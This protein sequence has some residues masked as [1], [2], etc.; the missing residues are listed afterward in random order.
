M[1]LSNR[2]SRA[3]FGG[4]IASI[5][6]RNRV[7]VTV[8]VGLGALAVI[9]AKTCDMMEATVELK[10][11]VGV[12]LGAIVGVLV[13]VAVG[14][15]VVVGVGVVV[16]ALAVIVAKTCDILDASVALKST[17]GVLVGV[18]GAEQDASGNTTMK[19]R[20]QNPI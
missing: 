20:I 7:G 17:V 8:G 18:G 2:I 16:G 15:L 13:G 10:F 14:I 1:Q 3:G 4:N 9:V 6:S 19:S 5:F 11:T 12:T